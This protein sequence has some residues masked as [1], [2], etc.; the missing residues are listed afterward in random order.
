MRTQAVNSRYDTNTSV[1][2][3]MKI[4]IIIFISRSFQRLVVTEPCN[5]QQVKFNFKCFVSDIQISSSTKMMIVTF[6]LVVYSGAVLMAENSFNEVS[7]R[8]IN[9]WTDC[10]VKIREPL[11]LMDPEENFVSEAEGR[12]QFTNH[13]AL[14]VLAGMTMSMPNTS[15]EIPLDI[16]S[17]IKSNNASILQISQEIHNQLYSLVDPDTQIEK[18]VIENLNKVHLLIHSTLL[19]MVNS[20]THPIDVTKEWNQLQG[21]KT[22]FGKRKDEWDAFVLSAQKPQIIRAGLDELNKQMGEIRSISD[23]MPRDSEIGNILASTRMVTITNMLRRK[24]DEKENADKPSDV[25]IENYSQLE[26]AIKAI[27]TETGCIVNLLKSG[28]SDATAI[29]EADK[30]LTDKIVTTLA[31]TK[32]SLLREMFETSI[33]VQ[34]AALATKLFEIGEQFESIKPKILQ[35]ANIV[36]D[37]YEKRAKPEWPFMFVLS[38]SYIANQCYTQIDKITTGTENL[39]HTVRMFENI[40]QLDEVH[41]RLV[42]GNAIVDD[43]IAKSG[44]MV[45]NNE[46]ETSVDGKISMLGLAHLYVTFR[47]LDCFF[48]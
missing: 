6:L 30:K 12:L 17:V 14:M 28:S 23:E 10:R 3:A 15:V 1:A 29:T 48:V 43:V 33:Y 32:M 44:N 13:C 9:E 25:K 7:E 35:L 40:H 11:D 24:L 42:E 46:D 19:G 2:I 39:Q 34:N 26:E 8:F 20:M 16:Y 38:A 36:K 4:C 21:Q 47:H 18:A 27:T 5:K 37:G 45:R 41:K 22:S 31:T